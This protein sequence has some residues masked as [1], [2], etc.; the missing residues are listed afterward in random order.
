MVTQ[1]DTWAWRG[2]IAAM[3]LGLH[4]ISHRAREIGSH[5]VA[6]CPS[7]AVDAALCPPFLGNWRVASLHPLSTTRVSSFDLPRG[8]RRWGSKSPSLS[9]CSSPTRHHPSPGRQTLAKERDRWGR[10]GSLL[11]C[12]SHMFFYFFLPT[13]MFCQPKHTSIYH[14]LYLIWF[15]K[16]GAKISQQW[17]LGIRLNDKKM[18]NVKWTYSF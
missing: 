5:R 8:S 15:Y 2:S 7:T 6:F 9:S 4:A 14:G 13:R 18:R 10:G 16:L 17:N 1:E 11:T 3:E 12:G